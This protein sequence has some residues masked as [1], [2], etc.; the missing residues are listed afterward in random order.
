VFKSTHMQRDT[1][2]FFDFLY[3]SPMFMSTVPLADYLE[4][5]QQ[6]Q[7][8][9]IN[10]ITKELCRHYNVNPS[11]CL[12]VDF[13]YLITGLARYTGVNPNPGVIPIYVPV[14][15]N[16][17]KELRKYYHTDL[18]IPEYVKTH[19][20]ILLVLSADLKF[21]INSVDEFLKLTRQF[22]IVNIAPVHANMDL[23]NDLIAT[24]TN[25]IKIGVDRSL[26]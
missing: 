1:Q 24:N 26:M 10:A 16:F 7:E 6:D 15:T 21:P 3:L 4:D 2:K 19:S 12:I 17:A 14:T 25:L 18:E 8:E 5:L 11:A 20:F 22:D 13:R 23:I 9:Q